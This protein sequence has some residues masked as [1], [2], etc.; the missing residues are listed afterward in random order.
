MR[1]SL[2]RPL[3]L[4]V[5]AAGLGLA[6]DE[7]KKLELLPAHARGMKE[8]LVMKTT[9]DRTTKKDEKV[10]QAISAEVV[11]KIKFLGDDGLSLLES[12]TFES[13]E[14]EYDDE[15]GQRRTESPG[16]SLTVN[17][18]RAEK[19]RRALLQEGAADIPEQVA[20]Q[21]IAVF[22]RDPDALARALTP[23]NAVKAG[24]TWKPD[25]AVLLRLFAPKKAK[26]VADD[27]D[28]EAKLESFKMKK[29]HP[30]AEITL[31]ATLVYTMPDDAEAKAKVR[32]EATVNGPADA[33]AAPTT[34]EITCKTRNP[35]GSKETLVVEIA[36]KK[37][38]AKQDE[39][40]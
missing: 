24:D 12:L 3:L 14:F 2:A 1:V 26:L 29:E 7:A 10:H 17:I 19:S 32:V 35:D 40:K 23:A 21:L 15:N 38:I 27:S 8:R 37:A 4:V 31:A 25:L 11:R 9:F 20:P 30:V 5:L 34:E 13:A 39:D 6:D 36:R 16:V 18:E 22:K 33:S 28:A